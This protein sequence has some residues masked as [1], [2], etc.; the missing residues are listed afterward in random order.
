MGYFYSID[1]DR[2]IEIKI[3]RSTF[4]CSL[5]Y[6][7][8]ISQ[9]KEFISLISSEHKMATH[10]CWA[11]TVGERGEI[12]HSSDNGEPA[13]TAGKPMMNV[14]QSHEMTNIAAVVT[15]YY[16]GVKLGVRGLIDAYG[17]AVTSAIT[18]SPLR[19][20]VQ[21]KK[22]SIDVPYPFN[23]TLLHRLQEL[24]ATVTDSRYSE[25]VCHNIEVAQ[26]FSSDL[27]I[28]LTEYQKSGRLKFIVSEQE[29]KC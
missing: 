25:S 2:R 24:Q 17:E 21:V 8:T 23:G 14:L 6:V 26:E 11:Y 22:Y 13:G 10:N 20:L 29:K 7:E 5:R 4:I 19:K 16:G 18:L 12:C 1:H 28:L 9:A 27:D 3:K 15:R